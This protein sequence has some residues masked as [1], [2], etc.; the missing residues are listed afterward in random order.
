MLFSWPVKKKIKKKKSIE[1]RKKIPG[2]TGNVSPK[3]LLVILRMK[4][5]LETQQ[6]SDE[7]FTVARQ[8]LERNA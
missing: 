2:I 7:I 5:I 1:K 8:G 4:T 6:V 3:Y